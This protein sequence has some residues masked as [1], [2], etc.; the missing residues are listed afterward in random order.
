MKLST[1]AAVFVVVGAPFS[2][3]AAVTPDSAI[4][5]QKFAGAPLDLTHFEIVDLTHALNARTLFWPT[6]PS[7]FELE[8]LSYGRTPGGWFYSANRF[9]TPEHGGTHLDAPIHFDSTGVTMERIP[10]D[11]LV[12]PAVV[13][14]VSDSAARNPDFRLT[15]ADVHAFERRHGKIPAG[16]MVILRTGW[17]KRWPDRK[18]Y[19]GDDTPGDASKLHFP[20]FGAE[21]ARLLVDE[22]RVG[23]LGLDTPSID[24]GASRDFIVHRIAAAKNVVGLENL[25]GLAALPPVG[26]IVFALPIKIEGGSGGPLRAIALIPKASR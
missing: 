24:Y 21:A 15:V 17:E 8:Q 2:A 13:I 11:R 26:A 7:T 5:T 23:A 18:A 12:A 10:L 19:F 25:R 9:C 4:S 6:S 3:G 14:D 20:S 22:R 16:A 1:V